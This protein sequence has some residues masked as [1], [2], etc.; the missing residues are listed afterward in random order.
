MHIDV[1]IKIGGGAGQGIQTVGLLMT[2]VCQKVGLHVMG[3]NDFE[4]RIRGGHS[5]FQLRIS[6]QPICAAHHTIHLLI[7]LDQ[8][9]YDLHQHELDPDGLIL[10][11]SEMNI[12]KP[13]VLPLAFTDMAKKAG[14]L[15]TANTVAAS[16]CLA[17]FGAPFEL[18]DQAVS[19]LFKEK[20]KELIDKNR[21][22]AKMGFMA[23]QN[24]PFKWAF[25][26]N[27]GKTPLGLIEGAQAIALGALA[28]DCRFAAFYPMSPATDIMV[29]LSKLSDHFPLV[30]EQAEDEIAAINMII[31]AAF[32]G[33]RSLTA[34]SGGGFCLM[35]EGLGLAGMTETPIVIVNAQRPG[36]ATGLPTRTAQGDLLFV[37]SASQDE[38]PRFVFAPGTPEEAYNTTARALE[39]SEKYQVP[40]IILSDHYFISSVFTVDVSSLTA[41]PEV[42]RYIANKKDMNDPEKYKRYEITFTGISPRALPCMGKSLVRASGNEHQQDGH[43]SEEISI[44]NQM[45]DK[46]KTKVGS[47]EKEI[48]RPHVFCPEADFLLVGW[49]STRGII[50]EAVHYLRQ[51]GIDVGCV[52]L[53]DMWPFPTHAIKTILIDKKF[54]MVEQNSTAQ[55]GQLIHLQTGLSYSA[56]ILKYDGRPFLPMEICEDFK[57]KY[58]EKAYA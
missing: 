47:M 36:P 14:S 44:R 7:C 18:F 50:E 24:Q 17:L 28:G 21:K 22:A 48:Q 51:E 9:T 31:G 34:T 23:V 5:F 1:S 43:L 10:A 57:K 29:H 45:V 55:C 13:G 58:K 6:D 11:E 42:K 26:W 41:P 8:K 3:I 12:S 16:A 30:V 35:T 33:T 19:Q 56:A 37:I 2:A 32:A 15:A 27:T 54:F 25:D 39:L 46:R 40:A 53:C 52:H 4:S 20:S 38:F 49:G